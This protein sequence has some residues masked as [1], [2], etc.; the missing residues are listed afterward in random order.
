MKVKS[1]SFRNKETD[2]MEDVYSAAVMLIGHTSEDWTTLRSARD[3]T[4]QWSGEMAK[5]F[6]D[7]LY[8]S[9]ATAAVLANQDRAVREQSLRDWYENLVSGEPGEKFWHHQW[10]VGLLHIR[11]GVKNTYVLAMVN[12][13]EAVFLSKC[14]ASFE[15]QRAIEL[16]LAF[17]RIV[18]AVGILIAEGYHHGIISGLSAVGLNPGLIT[19]MRDIAVK[20]MVEET[21]RQLASAS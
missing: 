1:S 10:L 8:S 18:D 20:K 11:A 13:V 16:Y 21:R 3:V 15:P 7:I 5:V 19:R 6:Y 12:Q 17:K 4:S 9:E 2:T 14:L